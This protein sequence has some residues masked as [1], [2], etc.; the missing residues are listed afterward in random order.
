MVRIAI[1]ILVVCV[2]WGN[3]HPQQQLKVVSSASI[4]EDMAKNLGKELISTSSIVPLGA[5]PHLYEP[6]PSDA[7][8]VSSA[9]VILVNGLTFEG[10]INELIENSGTK[11]K[12]VL[13]TEGITPIESEQYNNAVDPHAWMDANNGLIYA[14]NISNAIQEADPNNIDIYKR[15]LQEYQDELRSVDEYIS[16]SIQS[17]PEEKRILITSHDAFAYF[18]KKYGIKLSAIMG[19]STDADVQTSD[20]VR[21][22]NTIK[23]SG[24]PAVFIESTINPKLLERI[25]ADNDVQIGGELFSDSI[26]DE[27]SGAHGYIEMLKHNTDVITNALSKNIISTTK[28]DKDDTSMN[29]LLYIGLGV[30]MIMALLVIFL[31]ILKG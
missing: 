15:Y 26:G 27:D 7:V 14:Q 10:W 12:V 13:I 9:D 28:I 6:T 4:F 21:V 2:G 8:L 20:I 25:A 22:T 18:G 19:L 11:A 5:D 3:L 1:M 30:F 16:R 29:W 17:I 23:E 24:V 31:K